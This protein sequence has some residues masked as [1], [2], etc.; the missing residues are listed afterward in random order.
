MPGPLEDL[1]QELGGP[2]PAEFERLGEDDL[3]RPRDLLAAAREHQPRARR[4]AG[5]V[6]TG[7]ALDVLRRLPPEFVAA[8]TIEVDPRRV[9]DVIAAVPQET[10]VPVA[11]ILGERREYVTMGRFLAY[12]PDHAIVSAI[13]TLS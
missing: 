2:P 3:R 13:A 7:T 12:V 6:D 4:A 8:A 10:L 5:T 11:R 1:A 9:V